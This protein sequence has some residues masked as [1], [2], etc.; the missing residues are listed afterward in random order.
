MKKWISTGKANT[1]ID[2]MGINISSTR[3]CSTER[4]CTELEKLKT[5]D[6]DAMFGADSV[7]FVR[8]PKCSENGRWG[9]FNSKR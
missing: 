9:P 8:S 1:R 5:F 3:N 2:T 7:L 6:S 4:A